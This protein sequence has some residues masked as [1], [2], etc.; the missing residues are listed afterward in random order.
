M[1]GSLY[2]G[3]GP[4]VEL[5]GNIITSEKPTRTL[6][7]DRVPSSDSRHP[8]GG[9]YWGGF[10]VPLRA[11]HS[12]EVRSSILLVGRFLPAS[13]GRF[14]GNLGLVS[15]VTIRGTLNFEF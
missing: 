13:L 12:A 14:S 9:P 5:D 10:G 3:G 11:R 6:T 1:L 8:S 4:Q 15:L 2:A 7:R